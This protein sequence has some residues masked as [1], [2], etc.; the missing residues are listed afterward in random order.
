MRKTRLVRGF[1]ENNNRIRTRSILC[2]NARS[3]MRPIWWEDA[4]C[5]QGNKECDMLRIY[6]KCRK[7]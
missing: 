2:K 4:A 5:I 1:R 6:K 3:S 7:E